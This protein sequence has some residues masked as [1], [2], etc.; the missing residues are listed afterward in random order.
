MLVPV[1]GHGWQE[2]VLAAQV[3]GRHQPG[4]TPS[5]GT[6]TTSTD[7]HSHWGHETLMNGTCTALELEREPKDSEKTHA[8][9]GRTCKPHTAP[10]GDGF[11]FLSM[12]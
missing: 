3:Q 1:Q 9:P 6:V 5:R 4:Q 2:P 11:C 8:D 12:L 7:T 10:V